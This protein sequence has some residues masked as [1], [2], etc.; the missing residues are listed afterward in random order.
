[1]SPPT[2]AR[3]APARSN[4][5]LLWRVFE[6]LNQIS[7]CAVN[8]RMAC[9]LSGSP[10]LPGDVCCLCQT[11]SHLFFRH[12]SLLARGQLGPSSRLAW[13]EASFNF[14]FSPKPIRCSGSRRC[15]RPLVNRVIS[16]LKKKKKFRKCSISMVFRLLFLPLS[17][18]LCLPT[19]E[20]LS[21]CVSLSISSKA[22]RSAGT[23][24]R[25]R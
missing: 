18:C 9:A 3:G 17:L 15:T 21:H 11:E 6:T 23:M 12:F 10:T 1:M 22:R 20:A 5:P 16:K 19:S 25:R 7:L 14:C 8:L 13:R 2:P 24:S 4:R